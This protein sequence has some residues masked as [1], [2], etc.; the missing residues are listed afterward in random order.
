MNDDA[1]QHLQRRIEDRTA[2]VGII[3]VGYVGLPLAR[4]FCRAGYAVNGFDVDRERVSELN[5]GKSPLS[6]MPSAE[7]ADMVESGAFY[8]T[9][10]FKLLRRMD[11]A[12]ICVP[13]PLTPARDPDL[14]HVRSAAENIRRYMNDGM[15]VVL[16]STTYPGTTE[17]VVLPILEESGLYCGEDF[18]LAFSPEREDPGNTEFETATIPKVVG[19]VEERSGS[20]ACALYSSVVQEVVRVTDARTAEAAKILENIYRA[21]NIALVNELKVLFDRM[22]IDI[23]EVIRAASSKPFGYQALYPG[24]GLGGHCIPIDPFYLAW[25]AREYDMPTRFIELAGEINTVM[26]EFVVGKT[27]NALHECGRPLSGAEI[28][29]LGVAYKKDVSDIRESPALRLITLLS[30]KGA[31]VRYHDPHVPVLKPSARFEH[32]LESIAMDASTVASADVVLIVTDHSAVDYELI[33]REAKLIVDTRNV[34]SS[35]DGLG[36]RLVRA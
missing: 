30:E 27:M 7:L 23:W 19:G 21:V 20:L 2:H 22:D 35:F 10:D 24:P 6:H 14:S 34:M 16:E 9:D 32:A 18:F 3:G 31:Q 1:H 28:L 25:R 12:I 11:V 4:A 17:E 5:A 33:S 13:T 15:L 26:P 29:V 8:A 36:D